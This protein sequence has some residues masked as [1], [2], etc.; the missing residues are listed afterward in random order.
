VASLQICLILMSLFFK[1]FVNSVLILA[2]FFLRYYLLQTI[3]LLM[4]TK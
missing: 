3:K 1:T 2:Q 4:R